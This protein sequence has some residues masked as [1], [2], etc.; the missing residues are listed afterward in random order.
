M[1]WTEGFRN[2]HTPDIADLSNRIG[3]VVFV[4]NNLM[5]GRRDHHLLN[6]IGFGGNAYTGNLYNGW[7]RRADHI[8]IMLNPFIKNEK[9]VWAVQTGAHAAQFKGE[10][11]IVS[12]ATLKE[13][14]KYHTNGV[15]FIRQRIDIDLTYEEDI[16]T[17]DKQIVKS[18]VYHSQKKAWCYVGNPDYWW[19]GSNAINSM[20]FIPM[21]IFTPHKT[22]KDLYY[23]HS[24]REPDGK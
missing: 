24:L 6:P 4:Y 14:D 7:Y 17:K 12:I 23:F 20:D 10:L 18:G 3:A 21:P 9:P 13:L 22:W 16:L 19:T 15:E 8:P 5:K 2:G 1:S 11:Y